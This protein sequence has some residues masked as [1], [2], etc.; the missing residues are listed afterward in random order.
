[1]LQ[2]FERG[3]T[4]EICNGIMYDL[5]LG[6]PH[7]PLANVNKDQFHHPGTEPTL[8]ELLRFTCADRRVINIP[9]EIGIKYVE[10]GTYLLEDSTGSRVK[11]IAHKHHYN[12]NK[13]QSATNITV[14]SFVAFIAVNLSYNINPNFDSYTSLVSPVSQDVKQMLW[15]LPLK[16]ASRSLMAQRCS[17]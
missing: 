16:F 3:N 8:S 4:V 17:R 14:F 1:M 7:M 11:M 6:L 9:L 12:V 13:G 15:S 5:Y 10:F 2:C